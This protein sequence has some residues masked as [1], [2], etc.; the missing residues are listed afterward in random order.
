VSYVVRATN[1]LKYHACFLLFHTAYFTNV[2]EQI[3]WVLW[4]LHY[5]NERVETLIPIQQTYDP[6]V[7]IHST[8]TEQ[9]QEL[10]STTHASIEQRVQ[11]GENVTR[12]IAFIKRKGKHLK[13]ALPQST[14]KNMII[15]FGH[16]YAIDL[17]RK[18]HSP[19]LRQK[20]YDFKLL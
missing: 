14:L 9:K 15:H 13:H 10:M 16:S 7:T 1:L 3:D 17:S 18:A 19:S 2:I 12:F 4:T 11:H 5:Q 6:F 20:R 8:M